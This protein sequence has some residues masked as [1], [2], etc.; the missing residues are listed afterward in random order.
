MKLPGLVIQQNRI[1][2]SGLGFFVAGIDDGAG[3]LN[4]FQ[5]QL[6][7]GPFV[8]GLFWCWR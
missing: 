5:A 8:F 7:L 6:V 2:L 1:T 4:G 3:R